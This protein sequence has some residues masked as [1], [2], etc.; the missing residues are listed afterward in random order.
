MFW[1]LQKQ[2]LIQRKPGRRKSC[3]SPILLCK[4][5]VLDDLKNLN[6]AVLHPERISAVAPPSQDHRATLF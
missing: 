1:C 3:R 2:F 4:R 5:G 6:A